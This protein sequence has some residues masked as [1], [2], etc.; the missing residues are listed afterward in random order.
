LR[1]TDFAT[2]G[3]RIEPPMH[4]A[5]AA[6]CATPDATRHL[7]ETLRAFLS[8]SAAGL[9]RQPELAAM[10]RSV[11]LGSQASTVRLSLSVRAEDMP[12]IFELLTR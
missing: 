9:K 4:L 2:L 5:I 12:R 6:Q 7:E 3:L 1:M 10:L 8:L 11:E